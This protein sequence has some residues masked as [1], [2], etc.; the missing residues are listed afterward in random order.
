MKIYSLKWLIKWFSKLDSKEEEQCPVPIRRESQEDRSIH[1]DDDMPEFL[2]KDIAHEPSVAWEDYIVSGQKTVGQKVEHV[3]DTSSKG[4]ELGKTPHNVSKCS[5]LENKPLVKIFTECAD[6]LRSLDELTK[7][8]KSE[9]EQ[10]LLQMVREKICTVL[11]I[12]GGTPIDNDKSFDIIRHI[13]INCNNAVN[14]M[15]IQE[16]VEAGISLDDRVIVRAKVNL[17]I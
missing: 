13:S 9:R 5:L 2:K 1:I 17:K 15:P 8:F 11:L 16:F 3:D 10:F 12:S 6:L 4:V 14:G 7:D